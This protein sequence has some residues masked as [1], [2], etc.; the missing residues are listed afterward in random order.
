MYKLIA[1]MPQ[2]HEPEDRERWENSDESWPQ[3]REGHE[4]AILCIDQAPRCQASTIRFPKK[5]H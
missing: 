1:E 5:A 3:S 4:E 2:C